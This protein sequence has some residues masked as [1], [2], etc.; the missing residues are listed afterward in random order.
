V[1]VSKLRK[2]QRHSYPSHTEH[3]FGAPA[4]ANMKRMPGYL[5][6]PPASP[7]KHPSEGES[8][9]KEHNQTQAT[10]L[11][12]NEPNENELKKP[13]P[14]LN[15]STSPMQDS[16]ASL[17]CA[18]HLSPDR[19][20][21]KT[22]GLE[23]SVVLTPELLAVGELVAAMKRV[24]GVLGTTFDSLGEQTERVATLAPALKAAELIKKLRSEIAHV[25]TQ[26]EMQALEI[27]NSLDEAVKQTLSEE[28]K[29]HIQATVASEV[30]DRVTRQLNAQ[31]PENLRQQIKSHKRQILEVQRS[32][33]NSEA[34]QH[35][36]VLGPAALNVELRP[37]LRPLPSA[38]QSP[39]PGS[40]LPTPVP[41]SRQA[42]LSETTPTASPLFPRD[43][44]ALFAL[45]SEEAQTLVKEYGLGEEA[46]PVTPIVAPGTE[47][48][49]RERNLNKFMA[50]I[51]VSRRRVPN[52]R[53]PRLR[54]VIP[55]GPDYAV[56]TYY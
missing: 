18:T 46:V 16:L 17:S 40:V 31:I 29:A 30:T 33:H 23:L 50:H 2:T 42:S 19:T 28:I 56:N 54:V 53:L 8:T 52:A 34:R 41:I 15:I 6:T 1:Y 32:L 9:T 11:P 36:S 45:K 20:D 7:G 22:N 5:Y 43:L 21:P 13:P 48:D 38:E 14:N 55:G 51:G 12:P 44:K 3:V 10:E 49:S 47:P 4:V 35:N 24:V 37:L 25:I 39:M 26:S 27:K